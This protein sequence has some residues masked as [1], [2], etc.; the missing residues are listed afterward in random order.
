MLRLV[1]VTMLCSRMWRIVYSKDDQEAG[2]TG[3]I[4]CISKKPSVGV[5]DFLTAVCDEVVVVA[6][7]TAVAA[8]RLRFTLH[9]QTADCAMV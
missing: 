8:Y 3:G 5:F 4:F 6:G 7:S 2:V 9:K 1:V